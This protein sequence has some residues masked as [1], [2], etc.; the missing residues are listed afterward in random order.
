MGGQLEGVEE[1]PH[2]MNLYSS[3]IVIGSSP[4]PRMYMYSQLLA[5]WKLRTT[6]AD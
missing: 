5:P 4:L 3:V 1:G 2:R 6:F